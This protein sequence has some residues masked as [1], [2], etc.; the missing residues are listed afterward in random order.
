MAI[1]CFLIARM[2][3]IYH[4]AVLFSLLVCAALTVAPAY[5]A[6]KGYIADADTCGRC[7]KEILAKWKGSMHS[8]A[9]AD[10]IFQTAYMQAYTETAGKAKTVCLSCHAPTTAITGDFDLKNATTKEGITCHFC[11]SI[12]GAHPNGKTRFDLKV[13][14]TVRG[15]KGGAKS[16]YHDSVASPLHRTAELCAGCHE[17]S[18]NGIKIMGTYTEWKNGPYAAKGVVCQAC[19]MPQE[20]VTDDKGK[21]KTVMSHAL[22]GGHS[23]AQLRKAVTVSVRNIVKAAD[24]VTVEVEITNSGSGHYVPTGIPT[25]KLMLYCQIKTSDNKSMKKNVAFE[26]IIFD[27]TGREL[28]S[29]SE[30]M[31]G[32]GTQVV[33]DNRLA[34]GEK[35]REQLVFYVGTSGSVTATVWVDYLYQPLLVQP[36]EMR[37]ELSRTESTSK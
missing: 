27:K 14:T 16:D 6:G 28:L 3:T 20:A 37:I 1:H 23:E 24:R 10:P 18:A 31:M 35:R 29:D 15:P 4:K 5:A 34:P 2:R 13:S 12:T 9:V 33:K 17:Y 26:R 7:H 25:R 22:A 30:I 11:H 32:K 21:T 8:Q 36:T 19:H